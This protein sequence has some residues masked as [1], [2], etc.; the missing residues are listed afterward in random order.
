MNTPAVGSAEA[1]PPLAQI[2]WVDS[3]RSVPL[4]PPPY[5]KPEIPIAPSN[6]STLK[7]SI[8]DSLRVIIATLPS[9]ADAS[10]VPAA[11]PMSY[12]DK[13]RVA[14]AP[15]SEEHTSELQSRPH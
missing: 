6:A 2:T 14:L 11:A 5:L 4:A 9:A 10:T 13:S 7:S 1:S 3:I 12:A 8:R 15:R